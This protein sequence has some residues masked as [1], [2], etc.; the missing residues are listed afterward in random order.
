M[1]AKGILAILISVSLSIAASFLFNHYELTYHKN[2]WWSVLLYSLIFVVLNVVYNLKTTPQSFSEMLIGSI[3]I[4]LT[5]LLFA[6]FIYSLIDQGGL[7]KF[8]LH[9]ITHYILFTIFE[10]RFLLLLIKSK[11]ISK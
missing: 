2:W 6:I 8:S 10:I 5:I 4:K 7:T 11:E 9:F 1:L 3:A